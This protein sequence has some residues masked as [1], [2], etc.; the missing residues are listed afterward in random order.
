MKT[1]ALMLMLPI[2][3]MLHDFEEIIMSGRWMAENQTRLAKRFPKACRLL[4]E[5]GPFRFSAEGR[6][7]AVLCE[8]VLISAAA[9]AAVFSGFYPLWL[10]AFM[11]Y[12]LHLFAHIGQWI[13]WRGYIPAIMTAIL[14]LPYCVYMMIYLIELGF[15]SAATWIVWSVTGIV[16]TALSFPAAFFL[17][18]RLEQWQ[19]RRGI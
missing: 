14:S 9:S 6:A 19:R 8:F 10:A 17:A 15:F 18:G 4:T 2:V 12:F 16:L 11:A 13:L 1:D 7:V 5:K 3:F